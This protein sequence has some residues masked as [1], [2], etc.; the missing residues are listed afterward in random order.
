VTRIA[1][2]LSDG[3]T[4]SYEFYPPKDEE[5]ER[6]F[7][8]ALPKLAS[9]APTF[10]SVTYGALGSTRERTLE[11]V[12]KANADYPFPTMPHLTCVG[13]SRADVHRLLDTYR[14]AGIENVLALG[15]D[16]PAD[17]S[18]PGGDFEFAQELVEIVREIGGFGIAVAAQPELHPRSTDREKDRRFLAAK[19]SLSD[20]GI[21]NFFWEVDH[22]VRMMDELAELGCAKPV[23]PA[24]FP[25]INVPAALRMSAMNA[26]HVPDG[27]RARMEAVQD[28]PKAVRLLGVEVA[29][30]LGA[31][32]LEAGAPGLH[33]ITMNRSAPTFGVLES[34][35]LPRAH[36]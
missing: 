20:F 23:I 26:T 14:E 32:L 28:D 2:L 4:V 36:A 5:T 27:L 19:L 31:E 10:M 30:A 3:P 7:S 21:T 22:Y 13:H 15:G 34:L 9:T 8:R 24:I 11:I 16:P 17:G 18:D 25:F 6:N 12:L 33:I 35:G 1:D 29:S